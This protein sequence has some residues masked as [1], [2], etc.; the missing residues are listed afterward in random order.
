MSWYKEW[1]NTKYYHILYKNRD[2]NEANFFISNLINYLKIATNSKILDL[3]CGKGRHSIFMNGL[4]YNV[5]GVDLSIESIEIAKKYESTYLKFKTHDM[6]EVYKTN[7]FNYVFNLFTSFGYFESDDENQKVVDAMAKNLKNDGIVV[8]DFFNAEK[9]IKQL[10][11]YEVK[12]IDGIDF[13]ITKEFKKGYINK[14]IKF[15]DQGKDYFFTESVKALYQKDFERYFM[16]TGFSVLNT[17]GD[18]HLNT[19]D[20]LNSDR[21]IYVCKK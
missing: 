6:R 11:P 4:G 8:I 18:Y 9:T 13:E 19:F 3:A 12:S 2:Y 7:Y 15:N 10:V 17:F 21:L 5:E 16:K 20:F 1:F 14:N